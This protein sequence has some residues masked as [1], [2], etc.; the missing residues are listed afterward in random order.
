MHVR[1]HRH[2]AS[3]AAVIPTR[4]R[5]DGHR[6]V[7]SVDAGDSENVTF[8]REFLTGAVDRHLGR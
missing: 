7:L 5:A 3:K 8:W 6:E 2:I 1:K 4:L